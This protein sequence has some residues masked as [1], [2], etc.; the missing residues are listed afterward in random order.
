MPIPSLG[1]L[2]ADCWVRAEQAL[3]ENMRQ[4]F[5]D[6]DEEIITDH[7]HA[8]LE[9]ELN[10]VSENGTVV[11]SFLSDLKASFPKL[12]EEDLKS[13]IARRLMAT[14]NFH[15]R[16]VEQRTAGDLGIVLVRPDVQSREYDP[17][18]TVIQKDYR[19]GLLCQAKV[20][21]RDSKWGSL[22]PAQQ[23]KLSGK[24]GYFAVLLYRYID[25]EGDRRNLGPFQ[26]QLTADATPNDLE[27]WLASDKFPSLKESEQILCALVQDK[28]GTDDGKIIDWDIAPPLRS[29]LVI[30][31]AWKDGDDPGKEVRV[32][33]KVTGVQVQRQLQRH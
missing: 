27:K 1:K 21:R 14:V 32:H 28:I 29:S 7:F 17:S 8:E 33:Q 19:R 20:F 2:I 3:R 15:P 23:E 31:I 18:S 26:W 5:P 10:R 25:Q 13:K 16:H 30:R 9:S 11:W 4:K 12:S 6:R 22:S 24:L